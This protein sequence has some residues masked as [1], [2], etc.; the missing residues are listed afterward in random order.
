M[1]GDLRMAISHDLQQL[2]ADLGR[3]LTLERGGS[4][5]ANR[6]LA[7]DYLMD[8]KH[9]KSADV[10]EELTQYAARPR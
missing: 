4:P 2:A 7:A 10:I 6:E 8:V 5:V 3:W 9:M 1:T